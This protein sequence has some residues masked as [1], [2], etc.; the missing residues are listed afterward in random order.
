M[1]LPT[2]ARLM[3]CESSSNGS[4]A[5]ATSGMATT[6]GM[7]GDDESLSTLEMMC[8]KSMVRI[9]TSA[10]IEEAA[11]TMRSIESGVPLPPPPPPPRSEWHGCNAWHGWRFLAQEQ[12]R[13]AAETKEPVYSTD[14]ETE[15][16]AHRRNKKTGNQP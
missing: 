2:L 4:F 8:R 16:E 10:S 9:A 12:Q 11:G 3:Q 14:S 13:T 7:G 15:E 5:A 1:S 6:S